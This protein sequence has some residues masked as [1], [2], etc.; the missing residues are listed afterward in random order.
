MSTKIH[1]KIRMVLKINIKFKVRAREMAL[2]VKIAQYSLQGTWVQFLAPMWQQSTTYN[3]SSR[4]P[5]IL[6]WPP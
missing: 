4:G 5:S 1:F 2:M 6:F 3:S